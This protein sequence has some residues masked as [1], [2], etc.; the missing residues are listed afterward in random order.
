MLAEARTIREAFDRVAPSFD[1]ILET[2]PINAWMHERNL[3]VLRST[4]RAG[5]RLLE[6]G[7]GTGTAAIDLARGGHKVFAFDISEAMVSEARAKVQA[8]GLQERV[9]I[10]LG[11]SRDLLQVTAASPWTTF[12][13]GYANFSLT[14]EADLPGIARSLAAVLRPGSHFVCTLPNRIVLSELL[15]YG[16][17]LRF[18]NVLWRFTQPILKDVHGS[19]VKTYAFSPAEVREA[20]APWF[21]L[22]SLVGV[23]VFLPPP[24]LHGQYERL[25]GS[26][27]LLQ[28]LDRRLAARYPWNRCGEHTLFV[29]ER[30]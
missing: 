26:G 19:K 29:F 12:D 21:R 17:Q 4:F 18:R 15:V 9:V 23:P 13:G 7:C 24:Y 1:T 16:P 8:A 10:A 2:N 22:R 5:S 27:R 25:G 11:R 6:M 3:H 14:Y 28:G 30:T 20:F